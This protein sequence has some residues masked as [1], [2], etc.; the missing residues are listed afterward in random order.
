[1]YYFKGHFKNHC[2]MWKTSV[3]C[4]LI[5]FF[6]KMH[7]RREGR[8][9]SPAHFSGPSASTESVLKDLALAQLRTH[10]PC[11]PTV[12]CLWGPDPRSLAAGSGKWDLSNPRGCSSSPPPR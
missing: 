7:G 1:M 4:K 3:I 11:Y 12:A 8:A 2:S 5:F 9:A 6:R 10:A